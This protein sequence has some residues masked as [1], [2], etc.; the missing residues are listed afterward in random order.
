MSEKVTQTEPIET[1]NPR[2][3]QRL[4]EGND[5][6]LVDFYADWCAPCR[7]M[8]PAVE[9]VAEEGDVTVAK[10]NID[11]NQKVAS[12][13][14]VRSVPTLVLFVGGEPAKKTVGAKS[15]AELRG[16]VGN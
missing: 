6:V 3:F 1:K 16:F 8:E 7:A 11:E 12:A 4:V 9:A 13:Y 10:V 2:E 15:E 5:R 14:G